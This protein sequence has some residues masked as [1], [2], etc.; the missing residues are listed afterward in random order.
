MQSLLSITGGIRGTLMSFLLGMALLAGPTP[1]LARIDMED[2]WSVMVNGQ[3]L[4]IESFT[5]AM[6]PDIA[7]RELARTNK[8]YERF[9]VAD[10]RIFLTGVASGAHWLA[11]IHGHPDGAQGY[12]S[13]LY[14][15][16]AHGP[17]PAL[18][19]SHI[20]AGPPRAAKRSFP[21]GLQLEPFTTFEFGPA[22]SVGLVSARTPGPVR[23]KGGPSGNGLSLIPVPGHGA[24]SMAVAV[25]MPEH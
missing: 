12:V 10:G 6:S 19:A 7:A 18:A 13:A 8:A 25:L 14:F 2:R 22:A 5:S 15:D 1:C 23:Q 20:P 3:R 24:G 9:I 11:Q 16:P 21:A 4:T 17:G